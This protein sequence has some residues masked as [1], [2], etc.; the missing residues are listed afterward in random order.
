MKK[1]KFDGLQL[2]WAHGLCEH[3]SLYKTEDAVLWYQLWAAHWGWCLSIDFA[4]RVKR[5]GW[6]WLSNT[7]LTGTTWATFLPL[8]PNLPCALGCSDHDNNSNDNNSGSYHDRRQLCTV[9]ESTDSVASPMRIQSWLFHLL[10]VWPRSNYLTPLCF[11]CFLCKAETV[12]TLLVHQMLRAKPG[13]YAGSTTKA[14]N[15]INECS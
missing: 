8:T 5:K 9:V 13:M 4:L 10:I 15:K 2:P 6:P 7:A 3:L 14:L 11:S 12:A 1:R